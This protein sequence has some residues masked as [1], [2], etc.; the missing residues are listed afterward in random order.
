MNV[1]RLMLLVSIELLLLWIAVR[2]LEEE[3]LDVGYE[4]AHSSLFLLVIM[5]Q[6]LVEL[7]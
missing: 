5:E 7:W 6:Y 1:E 3:R 2:E 4:I